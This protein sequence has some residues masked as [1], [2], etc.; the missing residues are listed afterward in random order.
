MGLLLKLGSMRSAWRLLDSNGSGSLSYTEFVD[1][2]ERTKVPWKEITGLTRLKDLFNLFDVD[3]DKEVSLVEFLGFPD[4]DDEPPSAKKG[5]VPTSTMWKKYINN[6]KLSPMTC[7]RQSKWKTMAPLQYQ[8][9]VEHHP[10]ELEKIAEMARKPDDEIAQLKRV[11]VNEIE[12]KGRRI[13]EKLKVLNSYTEAFRACKSDLT[14]V[15]IGSKK[16]REEAEEL[17]KLEAAKKK[18]KGMTSVAVDDPQRKLMREATEATKK[19][20]GDGVAHKSKPPD[21]LIHDYFA[22]KHLE[23]DEREFRD[24]TRRYEIPMWDAC[25][26]REYFQTYDADGSGAI[27]REEFALV[28]RDM[29]CIGKAK[30]VEI[31]ETVVDQYFNSADKRR[32]GEVT[33]ENFL[34]WSFRNGV[35]A[36]RGK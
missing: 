24:L 11:H 27:D 36:N 23:E 13:T 26:I 34:V 10:A 16:D 15:T 29:F 31:P 33:F 17:E 4:V 5:P 22:E 21:D 9:E 3:G 12:D 28:V 19:L 32:C 7:S 6:V 18:F 14:D 1:G 8:L 2:I 35:F 20:E 25:K 30:N